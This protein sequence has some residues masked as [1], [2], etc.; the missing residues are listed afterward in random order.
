MLCFGAA[1]LIQGY[2]Y[3]DHLGR[4]LGFGGERL[5]AVSVRLVSRDRVPAALRH[6]VE[7]PGQIADAASRRPVPTLR[8]RFGPLDQEEAQKLLEEARLVDDPLSMS[9]DAVRERFEDAIRR[10]SEQGIGDPEKAV[11]KVKA[12]GQTVSA[13]SA[14]EIAEYLGYEA[15]E[16]VPRDPAPEGTFQFADA[17]IYDLEKA[18]YEDGTPT[19]RL[20]MVDRAGRTY[21][22]IPLKEEM[23][24]AQ[25]DRLYD[26]FQAAKRNP[27]L[28]VIVRR[29][30]MPMVIKF[31]RSKGQ[32]DAGAAQPPPPGS[33]PPRQRPREK[34]PAPKP[35]PPS[36]DES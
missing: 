1:G 28:M 9:P 33:E 21:A 17:I 6:P 22:F 29:M 19:Y 20:T 4:A 10:R 12:L 13:E 35:P 30:L 15:A 26:V 11:A 18:Q 27:A 2:A 8:E 16:Y 31:R 23:D 14:N 32:Q 34:P 25:Y 5:G 7:E 36:D 24:P 3:L